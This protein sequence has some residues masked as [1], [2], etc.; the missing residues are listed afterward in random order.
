MNFDN[1]VTSSCENVTSTTSTSTTSTTTTSTTTSTS[2]TVATSSTTTTCVAL[3]LSSVSPNITSNAPSL[4]S[5]STYPAGLYEVVYLYGAMR[6]GGGEDYGLNKDATRGFRISHSGG[7]I[8]E[9]PKTNYDTFSS[10]SG[11]E[12]NNEDAA[13]QFIHSGGIIYMYLQ[14]DTYVDNASGET[15]N[16]T[17][18]LR[19]IC[20]FTSTTTST[21]TT[22]T[23]TSTSTTVVTTTS[24]TT[25]APTTTSVTSSPP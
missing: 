25:T 19:Q 24:S 1:L 3:N 14:D 4:F 12:G 13:V 23:T 21:T 22:P 2:T 7:I 8:V 5:L 6:Y 18:R 11:V 16:P 10:Q 15:A 17:F 20:S 9:G